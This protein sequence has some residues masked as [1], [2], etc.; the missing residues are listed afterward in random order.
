[1]FEKYKKIKYPDFQAMTPIK[2]H[3]TW[4]GKVPNMVY[5]LS[6]RPVNYYSE[7]DHA[8]GLAGKRMK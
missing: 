8:A 5:I 3:D 1:M 2:T 4:E 7:A 6:V